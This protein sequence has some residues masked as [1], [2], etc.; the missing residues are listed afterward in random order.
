MLNCPRLEVSLGSTQGSIK[1]FKLPVVV[2]VDCFLK[3]VDETCPLYCI[4]GFSKNALAPSVLSLNGGPE[5]ELCALDF[6][7]K[8]L[9]GNKLRLVE[10]VE[11]AG[12]R[13]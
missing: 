3:K 2:R 11:A 7:R 5:A 4:S 13:R 1:A 8:N 9:L 10:L 6:K 12:T